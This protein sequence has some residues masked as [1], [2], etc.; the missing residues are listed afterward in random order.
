MEVDKNEEYTAL[1]DSLSFNFVYSKDELA[2]IY[3][4]R[5]S[6]KKGEA[7]TILPEDFVTL[8]RQNKNLNFE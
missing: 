4:R 6:Y 5:D 1:N 3:D 7:E 2:A 8:V